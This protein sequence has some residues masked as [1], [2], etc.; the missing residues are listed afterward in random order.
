MV[1][2]GLH[3]VVVHAPSTV[4]EVPSQNAVPQ[5]F[6]IAFVSG[7]GKRDVGVGPAGTFPASRCALEEEIVSVYLEAKFRG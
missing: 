7:M 4:L 1:G 6:Q 5:S 2:D 3:E